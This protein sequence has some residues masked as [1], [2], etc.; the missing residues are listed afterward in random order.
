MAV[1]EVFRSTRDRHFET[2]VEKL[3]VG[4]QAMAAWIHDADGE[5]LGEGLIQLRE[6]GIDPLEAVFATGVRRFDSPASTRRTAR[7]R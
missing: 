4:V 2:A 7:S 6:A 1:A 3:R 5:G